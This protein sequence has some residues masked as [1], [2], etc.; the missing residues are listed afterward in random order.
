MTGI[1]LAGGKSSRMGRNKAFLEWEGRPLIERS[2]QV[3]R[4]IFSEIMISTNHPELYEQYGEK[5][6]TDIFLD[7]GPLGG[8]HACLREARYDYSLFVACDMPFINSE[9]IR[10]LAGLTGEE[11]AIV[12]KLSDGVHPL[13]AFYHRGCIPILEKRLEAKR[14]KL[15]NIFDEFPVRYVSEQEFRWFPDIKR[16]FSNVNTLQEWEELKQ[17]L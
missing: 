14:L 11:M 1:I 7:Q 9:V 4:S 10:F 5:M 8:L 13:H 2:L 15:I 3:F 6:V 12:P 17:F 16:V